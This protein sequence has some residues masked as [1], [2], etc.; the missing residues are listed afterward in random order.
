LAAGLS[1]LCLFSYKSAA[2]NAV[3]VDSIGVLALPALER[4]HPYL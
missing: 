3:F 4:P 2:V 1:D